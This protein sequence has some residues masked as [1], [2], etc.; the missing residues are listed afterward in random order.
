MSIPPEVLQCETCGE[1]RPFIL[2]CTRCGD[3]LED[4]SD[5]SPYERLNITP[6]PLY[7][8]RNIRAAEERVL[9]EFHAL[10]SSRQLARWSLKQRALVRRDAK[11]LCSLAGS[12][13]SYLKF[14]IFHL[15][16]YREFMSWGLPLS[17]TLHALSIMLSDHASE[18]SVDMTLDLFLLDTAY[19]EVDE[20][21]GYQERERLLNHFTR[22]LLRQAH[23]LATEL[24]V[25]QD[26]QR[27]FERISARIIALQHL[28]AWIDQHRKKSISPRV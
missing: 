20:Y 22:E 27:G 25:D 15:D 19:H 11:L 9:N 3:R 21:D 17:H 4:S 12:L 23:A 5:L 1:E 8:Q 14:S 28:E 24:E 26:D 18:T 16:E 10:K 13:G 6:Q 7:H 2:R